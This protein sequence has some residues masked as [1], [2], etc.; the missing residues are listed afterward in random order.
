MQENRIDVCD[1]LL[2]GKTL[3]YSDGISSAYLNK[4]CIKACKWIIPAEGV[5]LGNV[6]R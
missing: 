1:A 4:M 3:K 5:D 2:K 6:K